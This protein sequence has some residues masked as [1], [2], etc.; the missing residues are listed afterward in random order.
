MRQAQ[1]VYTLTEFPTVSAILFQSA[2]EP[3]PPLATRDDYGD[4]AP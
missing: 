3:L 2:G 4:L 1:V